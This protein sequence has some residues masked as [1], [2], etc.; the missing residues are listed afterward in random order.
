VV[1]KPPGFLFCA[2]G[3]VGVERAMA[4]GLKGED[5]M[6]KILANCKFLLDNL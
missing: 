5:A 1:E 3:R 6:K 4:G 2:P